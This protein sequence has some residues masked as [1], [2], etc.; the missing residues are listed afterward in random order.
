MMEMNWCG[1]SP[2][3]PYQ[4]RRV[5]VPAPKNNEHEEANHC[6]EDGESAVPDSGEEDA[7]LHVLQNEHNL[8][9][10]QDEYPLEAG[11]QAPD[12]GSGSECPDS[13]KS[14]H[15]SH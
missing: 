12:G 11:G 8:L 6:L 9:E 2:H 4:D 1:D 13:T 3:H 15:P 5:A 7:E 10:H 14:L